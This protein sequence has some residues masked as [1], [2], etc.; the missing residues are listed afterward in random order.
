M[1]RCSIRAVCESPTRIVWFVEFVWK[2]VCGRPC[3]RRAEGDYSAPGATCLERFARFVSPSRDPRPVSRTWL[4]V[5]GPLGARREALREGLTSIGGPGC[6]IALPV[7]S[8][9]QLQVW[10][11]PPRMLFL[12]RGA[13]PSLSGAP[14]EE[15]MLSPGDRIEWRG[16][17][18]V[19]GD[20]AP[21]EQATLEELPVLPGAPILMD[22]APDPLALRVRAG[23]ACELGLVEPK[24][25][26]RWRE[27][28]VAGS[29]DADACAREL[30][31]DLRGPD[32][33][34][35]LLERSGTLLRDFLMAPLLSGARGAARKAR[36]KARGLVAYI[37][38]QAV[39]LLVFTLIVGAILLVLRSQG[40]SIDA[41]LDVVLP[42]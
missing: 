3:N 29:F 7:E 36:E 19:Y 16:H 22:A 37:V 11:R 23:L 17:V 13:R 12:G 25:A 28:V 34:R 33:E 32:A 21:P 30:A 42:G 24:A 26:K 10:N 6:D 9:D 18:L 5:Q 15:R 4:E 31:T 1:S 8:T 14:F 35:R 39:A 38:S 41:F 2:A 27:R 40:R 20:D